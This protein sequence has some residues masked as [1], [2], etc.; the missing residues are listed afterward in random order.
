MWGSR[1]LKNKLQHQAV[2]Q[3]VGTCNKKY[4]I[5]TRCA[6]AT[7]GGRSHENMSQMGLGFPWNFLNSIMT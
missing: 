1:S 3:L 4:I 5:A 2:S 6:L 7:Q